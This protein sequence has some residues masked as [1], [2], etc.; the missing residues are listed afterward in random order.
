[1]ASQTMLAAMTFSITGTPNPHVWLLYLY[2]R[3][4]AGI[5]RQILSTVAENLML[6]CL[7][8]TFIL[9]FGLGIAQYELLFSVATLTPRPI[10]GSCGKI[11]TFAR[12]TVKEEGPKWYTRNTV[13]E[14]GIILLAKVFFLP[15]FTLPYYVKNVGVWLWKQNITRNKGRGHVLMF[16]N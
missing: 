11:F 13:L 16:W 6:S 5:A 8:I 2:Y 14:N 12:N 15:L 4:P 3:A 10:W 7:D 9:H 1:M